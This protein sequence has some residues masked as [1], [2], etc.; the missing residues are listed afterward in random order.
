[1]VRTVFSKGICKPFCCDDIIRCYQYL[2]YPCE[3][4]H[5]CSQNI[6][7]RAHQSI[8]CSLLA[9]CLSRSYPCVFPFFIYS[10]VLAISSPWSSGTHGGSG[11]RF[12]AKTSRRKYPENRVGVLARLIPYVNIIQTQV[13]QLRPLFLRTTCHHLLLPSASKH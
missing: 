7:S 8:T 1:M 4:S 13:F 10:T 11:F 5:G 3:P 9:H 12:G 2:Q 6:F